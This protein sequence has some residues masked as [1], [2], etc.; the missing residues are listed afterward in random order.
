MES[1]P[2]EL[3]NALDLA[4]A[5]PEQAAVVLRCAAGYLRK[6]D[7]LPYPL[8][9]F[10]AEAFENAMR[11]APSVRGSVLLLNLKLKAN[12]R[13]R[14]AA[15]FEHVGQDFEA[16]IS[17]R[18]T[19]LEASSKIADRYGISESVVIRLHKKYKEFI[20]AQL[21][22]DSMI[23]EEEQRR[24]SDTSLPKPKSSTK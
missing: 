22:E 10:L 5:D 15:N 13:R 21:V 14:V 20:A 19:V 11:R 18:A 23:H 16:C 24:Y 6:G 7:A 3:E 1:L 2:V 17:E 9:L 8:A 4:D 12:N